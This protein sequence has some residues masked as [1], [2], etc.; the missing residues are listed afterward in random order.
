ML[1]QLIKPQ[2]PINT[3]II[4][5]AK[6]TERREN[7]IKEFSN[8]SEFRVTVV[9][10]IEDPFGAKGLWKTICLVIRA[11]YAY[12]FILICEDDHKFT[13]RYSERRLRENI[14]K[15]QHLGA[16]IL[17]GGVSW[18]EDSIEI[19]KSLFWTKSFSGLQF[20]VIFNKFFNTILNA[21]LDGFN[22]ADY[23]IC[24][25][26]RN[27]FLMHPYLSIQ[28]AYPYSDVTPLNNQVGRVEQL[29]LNA[30]AKLKRLR[31][32]SRFFR[33][34]EDM[35]LCS[36][37]TINISKITIPTYI[38]NLKKRTDRKL[39][40]TEQFKSRS[41]FQITFREAISHQRGQVGL[42]ESIR[43]VIRLAIQNKDDVVIICE[44]D[45]EFTRYYEKTFLIKNIIKAHSLGADILLGGICN[46]QTAV[47]A[48]DNLF[49]V[50]EFYCT[51]FMVVYK[52]VFRDILE[53]NYDENMTVD[54]KISSISY[55]KMVIYPFVSVQKDFGYSDITHRDSSEIR[56]QSPFYDTMAR[57]QL[58]SEKYMSYVNL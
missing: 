29:F 47:R 36:D 7:I 48:S 5:L 44:D 45:H 37:T 40:I 21:N 46:Y 2:N 41:E 50:D 30:D 53:E 3:Y 35:S 18:S 1:F 34:V 8:R 20:T 31:Q 52:K 58:L 56:S 14:S 54:G 17:L 38:I 43:C 24:D 49:W 57:L 19:D 27:V 42:W 10:A 12:D 26:S 22:A 33:N 25:L 4:N 55:N 28:R 9:N 13:R 11:S 32:I 16:D 23:H 15:A 39:H 51:Q 6:R